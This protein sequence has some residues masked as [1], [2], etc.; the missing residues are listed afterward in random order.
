MRDQHGADPLSWSG[1][2]A[3]AAQTW[4]DRC[5]FVH[6][7]GQL[8]PFGENLAAGTGAGFGPEAAVQG[9]AGEAAQFNAADPE[10]AGTNHFT[11]VVWKATT[12]VGCAVAE[13]GGILDGVSD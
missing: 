5:A 4:A 6:S 11:Q 8:G 12:Q 1:T 9:W 3:D 13:C 10:K 7:G 2:L